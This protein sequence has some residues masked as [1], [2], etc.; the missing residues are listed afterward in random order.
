MKKLIYTPIIILAL[1]LGT[2]KNLSAQNNDR[3]KQGLDLG[4]RQ[5]YEAGIASCQ[6]TKNQEFTKLNNTKITV[7]NLEYVIDSISRKPYGITMYLGIYPRFSEVIKKTVEIPR[8][9]N[10]YLKNLIYYING[11]AY[12]TQLSEYIDAWEK[13][14]ETNENP[15]IDKNQD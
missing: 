1:T 15:I 10:A 3:Y 2:T 4:Y 13:L 7:G 11:E 14:L 5:G 9:K 8:G 12:K 6:K